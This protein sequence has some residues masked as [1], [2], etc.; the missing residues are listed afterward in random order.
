MFHSTEHQ[1]NR[2]TSPHK[3]ILPIRIKET[4]IRQASSMPSWCRPSSECCNEVCELMWMRFPFEN[5]D[6]FTTGYARLVLKMILEQAHY[7]LIRSWMR[8]ERWEYC[9]KYIYAYYTWLH[10]IIKNSTTII[11]RRKQ[12]IRNEIL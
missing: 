3:D 6:I 8:V 4:E 7:I 10:E 11:Q 5:I 12:I 2:I 1:N 9:L